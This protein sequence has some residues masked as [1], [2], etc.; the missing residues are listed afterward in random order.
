MS[1]H[2]TAVVHATA[3]LGDVEVGPFAVIGADVELADGVSVGAHSVVE[4]PCRVGE[5]TVLHPHVV[6]G[7]SPQDIKHDPA[8]PTRL[9][10]GARNVFREFTTAHRGSSGG[11]QVTTIGD[12]NYFMANSHVAHD[13]TIGSRT[14][15]ANS[16]AIAGHVTVADGAILGGLCAIH[17][18][19][20]IGRLA[21]VGGGAMCAQDVPPFSIAQ[22][23]RARLYGLNIIGLRRAGFGDETIGVL[24]EAWRTLFMDGLPKRVALTRTESAFGESAEVQELL[25]FLRSSERGICRA[26][27]A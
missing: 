18:F 27:L 2:P 17:Q 24:K 14:M 4:G 6:L 3:R 10:I 26:G 15:F 19:S 20:R 9:E 11:R 5:G 7:G 16:A 21:M 25:A 22:G 13:C 1:I 8:V 23:D 12:D